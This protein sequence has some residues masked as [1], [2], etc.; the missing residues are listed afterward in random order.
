M[1][2]PAVSAE[3]P[4][5]EAILPLWRQALGRDYAA[6]RNHVY[7]VLHFFR[8]FAGPDPEGEAQA[9]VAAC[10]HDLGIWT[11]RTFDYLEPSARLA[12][13]HLR[14][15]GLEGWLHEVLP[16]VREHHKLSPYRN[17]ARADAFRRADWTDVSLG[18]LRFGLPAGYVRAVRRA[19]PNAGFHLRL[20]QLSLRRLCTHP[21]SPLPML[22]L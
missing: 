15:H 19:F 12:E 17:S 11:D 21:W 22:K 16:M 5:V 14:R 13:A 6:Y 8:A 1:P 20:V 10:F 7:R 18:L 3:L 9:A 2:L 4:A